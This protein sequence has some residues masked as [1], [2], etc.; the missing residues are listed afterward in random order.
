M[1]RRQ[2]FPG[3]LNLFQRM[4][5]QWRDIH[6]YNAVHVAHVDAVFDADD[7]RRCVGDVIAARGL[8]GFALDAGRRRFVYRGGPVAPEV[9]VLATAADGDAERTLAGE[10]ERQL[11]QPF[12][13][14]APFRFFALP[15]A[16]GFLLGFAYDHFIAG[17]DAV[18]LLLGEIA[19]TLADG[20]ASPR[21][22]GPLALYPPTY[23]ALVRRHFG[24]FVTA[25][26][27][28]PALVRESKRAY[29]PLDADPDDRRNA[30]ALIRVAP[31][32]TAALRAHARACGVRLHDL[33]VA[34]LLRSLSPFA[35]ARRGERSRREI[36]VASIV[37]IRRDFDGDEARAF[38]QLLASMRVTHAV[39]DDADIGDL[40][41][42]V[43]DTTATIK[44]SRLYLRTLFGLA[45]ASCAWRFLS[46]AQ[47]N[48]FFAK[49]Y[50]AL[51]G[52]S[53]L[54][55]DPLWPAPIAPAQSYTRGVSTGP[56]T[57]AVLAIST[58]AGAMS[59]G[60]SWRRTVLPAEF[61][62]HLQTE[63]QRCA[64]QPSA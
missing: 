28:M 1:S 35:T 12:A 58:A 31:T 52:I 38:G 33:V 64:H 8:G 26:K 55:V 63:I 19:A 7:V 18:A 56:L 39:P 5:L 13:I 17:G 47:R 16:R 30:Y 15:E 62:A 42:D 29:R 22:P 3:K 23:A 24:W 6:P 10:I 14:G 61:P 20:N 4:M 44:R 54:D 51:A 2:A 50:P 48:R 59:I 11:N 36:G 32:E 43:R 45:A 27:S 21:L 46:A 40:A 53:M 34:L 60:V 49:H 9:T 41:R 25:L 37:N 57:P